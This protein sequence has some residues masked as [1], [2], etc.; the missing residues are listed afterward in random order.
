MHQT[1]SKFL[2]TGAI[3]YAGSSTVHLL[4]TISIVG[5]EE[6]CHRGRNSTNILKYVFLGAA[7]ALILLPLLGPRRGRFEGDAKRVRLP[8]QNNYFT[9]IGTMLL[10]FSW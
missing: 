7:P 4:G 8:G 2:G 9:T 3:D 6:L 1:G 10:W 5:R